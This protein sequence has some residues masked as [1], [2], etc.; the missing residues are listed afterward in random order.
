MKCNRLTSF[1]LAIVILLA[2]ALAA[3]SRRPASE[4]AQPLSD[5]LIPSQGC[6]SDTEIATAVRTLSQGK[7]ENQ[8]QTMARLKADARQSTLCRK[9][10]ITSM[11]SAMD[12]PDV[13]LTGS[14]PQFFLWHYGTQ[15]LGE[16]KATEALDLFIA[17]L[18][19]HDGSGFPFNHYP[20]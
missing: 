5:N 4:M 19:R 2:T 7:Y 1:S 17:N 14:T 16:L 13:D 18:D 20:R 15:L 9:K 10:V 8:R 12:Q 11:L 6:L 3:E